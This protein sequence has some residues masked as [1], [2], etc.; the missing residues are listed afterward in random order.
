M[1][2][3]RKTRFKLEMK[4]TLQWA[5]EYCAVGSGYAL[6]FSNIQNQP[7]RFIAKKWISSLAQS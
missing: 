3:L 7:A 6:H 2:C 1:A 5:G 4:N